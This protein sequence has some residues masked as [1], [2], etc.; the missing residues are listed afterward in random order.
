[1]VLCLSDFEVPI[2]FV[3]EQPLFP[4]HSKD[5]L[6]SLPHAYIIDHFLPCGFKI[7]VNIIQT[8]KKEAAFFSEVFGENIIILQ[9][10]SQEAMIEQNMHES[11][12]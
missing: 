2:P 10:M 1:M 5:R 4:F 11:G 7:Y 9:V 8:L 6:Q 12:N 3:W